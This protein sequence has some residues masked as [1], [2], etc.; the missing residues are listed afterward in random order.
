M[1]MF[2]SALIVICSLALSSMPAYSFRL[3]SIPSEQLVPTRTINADGG[4]TVTYTF[5]VAG[6]ADTNPP[7]PPEIDEFVD[8]AYFDGKQY[9]FFEF[10]TDKESVVLIDPE[11]KYL[12]FES[13]LYE[14]DIT[15]PSD[16][17][18]DGKTYPV[19][20]VD[21]FQYC[22]VK[23]VVLPSTVIDV[24]KSFIGCDELES[25]F[26][27][28]SITN[29]YGINKCN[30]L[31]LV[32][33]PEGLL[34]ISNSVN[35]TAVET[36]KL[37]S[38]IESVKYSFSHNSS[39]CSVDLGITSNV[40]DSFNECSK[41][42]EVLIGLVSPPSFPMNSF[43]DVDFAS[44]TLYVPEGSVNAYGSAE[45]WSRFGKIA[46]NPKTGI[47]SRPTDIEHGVSVT[48]KDGGISISTDSTCRVSV[49]D[50][51]GNTVADLY[52]EGCDEVSLPQGIYLVKA[53]K[54]VHKVCVR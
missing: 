47:D 34:T 41:I 29:L 24:S 22:G 16:I 32:E 50:S 4:V 15:V 26:L 2:Y 18:I 3:E 8:A 30:N 10:A 13:G 37:P 6:L 25:L 12:G 23:S 28:S 52:I 36:I 31:R 35:E 51:A 53:G 43:G 54:S 49:T 1:K 19:A 42:R 9:L 33:L 39:L 5:P 11:Y 14:G 44:C 45:G 46:V 27:S 7:Y 48:V 38:S 20:F 40:S 21:A 17:E